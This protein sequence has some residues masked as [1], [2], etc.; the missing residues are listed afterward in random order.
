MNAEQRKK[1]EMVFF[2]AFSKVEALVEDQIAEGGKVANRIAMRCTH[3]GSYQGIPP[4]GKR[5]LI[6]YIDIL[7]IKARKIV[8][9]WVEFDMDSIIKQIEASSHP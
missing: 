2:S 3:A 5:I 1:D 6:P 4:T 9:E 8:E 7:S